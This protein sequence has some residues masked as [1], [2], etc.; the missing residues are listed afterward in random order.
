MVE[1]FISRMLSQ[2]DRGVYVWGGNGEN[3]SGMK[4]PEEWIDRRETG[5]ANAQRAKKTYLRRVSEG[6]CPILAFDCSGLIYWG[7]KGAG[8]SCR[9]RSARGFH[10]ASRK[11]EKSALLPGDLVFRRNSSGKICHVGA[12]IGEGETVECYGRDVGVIRRALGDKWSD[13]GR[14]PAFLEEQAQTL[15]NGNMEKANTFDEAE[16]TSGG[17]GCFCRDLSV[18]TPLL[19][20]SDVRDLQNRL[21]ALG[22]CVGGSGADGI[23][24]KDTQKAVRQFQSNCAGVGV[25][26]IAD[27]PTRLILGIRKEG[28]GL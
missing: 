8:A 15:R 7:M 16:H 19:R 20:G 24:G 6:V 21:L 17:E 18:Q 1:S 2:V 11:I 28:T 12:Y 26:G 3:L 23:Y 13:Y 22:Y 10:T 4:S 25:S 27:Q 9:D 14:W 5:A